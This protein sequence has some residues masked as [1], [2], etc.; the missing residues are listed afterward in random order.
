MKRGR[1]FLQVMQ[2]AR[3]I[4]SALGRC[5]HLSNG[6]RLPVATVVV[7]LL[8]VGLVGCSPAGRDD[9]SPPGEPGASSIPVILLPEEAAEALGGL[10][11]WVRSALPGWRRVDRVALAQSLGYGEVSRGST[12]ANR[13]ALTFDGGSG[14]EHTPAILETLEAAGVKATFFIT[15]QFA[16]SF[17]EMVRRM[18]DDGHEFGNHSYNHPRFTGI[19][20]AEAHS[21]ISR[22]EAKVVELTGISTVPYLRFP[23]G[24]RNASLVRQV[25][26]LG[27]MSVFWTVDTLDW[28]PDKTCEQIRS[29]VMSNAC[30][31]AIVLMHCNSSQEARVLGSIIEDLQAAGYEVVTLTEVLAL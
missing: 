1:Q 7:F 28:M 15:G 18:A 12:S 25:N 24:A 9:S 13:I 31:G 22:T 27:Y 29:R 26:A 16:E 3:S 14:A 21:Q 23:Y 6:T 10:E 2:I 20:A 30:P 17:P 4:A 8:V 11:A 19:S 5:T